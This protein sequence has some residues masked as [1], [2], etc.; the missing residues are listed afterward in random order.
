MH[1][2][3]RRAL[4][5]VVLAALFAAGCGSNGDGTPAPEGKLDL[6]AAGATAAD[7]NGVL[8]TITCDT[9]FTATEYVPMDANGLPPHISTDLAGSPFAD[10]FLTMP[11]GNCDV[12]A[13]AMID[14]TT[15]ADGCTP[16]TAN[17]DVVANET[18][19][20]LLVIVCEPPPVGALD[21]I[22]VVTDGP[23]VVDISYDPSKFIVKCQ[24]TTVTVTTTGT[25][26]VVTYAVVTEPAGA[27]YTLTPTA[28]G[29]TFSA[30]VPGLYEIEI[31]VTANGMTSTFTIPI[32]VMD[33]PNLEHCDEVCCKY[34]NG[35][36]NFTGGDDCEAAGGAPVADDACLETV[37]CK[38][39][40]GFAFVQVSQCPEGSIQAD[41][42]CE[43]ICCVYPDGSIAYSATLD[44]CESAGGFVTA[45]EKCDVEVCC[46][47][48]AGNMVVPAADC[49]TGQELAADF[50]EA[51]D[52][53]CRLQE[54][55]LV[56]FA[57][58]EECAAMF[59]FIVAADECS[60]VSC[61][62]EGTTGSIQPQVTCEAVGGTV[63]P[64][65]ECV[66]VCCAT[67]GAASAPT[68][69]A[70]CN[71]V[72]GVAVGNDECAGEETFVWTADYTMNL[73][74]PCA[75]SPYL[76]VPS[77]SAN[78]LAVYD[79]STLL[80]L[81][82]TPFDTCA[83]PSRIMMDANTD[84]YATCRSATSSNGVCKHTR[85]GT[86][87]WC[88]NFNPECTSFRGIAMS[89]DGRLFVGCS[90][91]PGIVY[92]LNPAT[93][94]TVQQ[95][96]IAHYI[97]GFTIDGQS[98]YATPGWTG[99]LTSIDLATFTVN[100]SLVAPFAGLSP[101]GYGITVDQ[102]GFVWTTVGSIIQ[103]HDASDGT[104]LDQYSVAPPVGSFGVG[105]YGIQA[106]LD[107]L[108]YASDAQNN[109]VIQFDP[110]TET[111]N[112]LPLDGAAVW[113][114]GLTLDS[115]S[116]VYTINNSS[117]SLTKLAVG[118]GTPTAFGNGGE[119]LNPYGY[120]GDMTGMA[121][122]CLAGSVDTW[123]STP[124][125]S[126][127]P[128]TVWNTISWTAMTPPGTSAQVYYRVDGAATWTLAVNGGILGVVGQ[129]FEVK[130]IL[131]AA[132][133]AGAATIND[134]TVTY[135]IP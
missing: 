102:L 85:L 72:G 4:F 129:V 37:C 98:L 14:E 96:T 15:V 48:A 29:F 81:P 33:D 82:G 121:T 45:H 43:E 84:V 40:T 95:M 28:T 20:V 17:V 52:E 9:G 8:Y 100:Y 83:S 38:T 109:R 11:P 56:V 26:D 133:G 58:A 124:I 6:F 79:L 80:P 131:S 31:T 51:R 35:V 55:G 113:N 110:L 3:A 103:K 117:S 120:S 61:C 75:D 47:T 126:G 44:E 104:V 42:R 68:L 70:L 19:E 30:E 13:T 10:L 73:E 111:Y 41:E 24:E 60:P 1:S 34:D 21:V 54:S 118:T 66:Q 135:T 122:T 74:A 32:H 89:G 12:T 127:D 119:L 57:T 27:V 18:T 46:K 90:S 115:A 78:E 2:G 107:G 94:A 71:A 67:D 128:T 112:A 108:V 49:P 91:N 88:R 123:Y 5:A 77:T 125:D 92:E 22:A 63:Y 116:N 25:D 76:A 132:A 87:L 97:Y 23:A 50:C 36:F 16:A 62:V 106:G 130:V 86:T 134:V 39:P 93:G 114:H 99:G 65:A 53:C 105:M 69:L 59:G 101:G 64:E 7:V